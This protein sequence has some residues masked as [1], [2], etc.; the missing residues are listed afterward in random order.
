MGNLDQLKKLSCYEE[1]TDKHG[2]IEVRICLDNTTKVCSLSK[3]ETG[4][5]RIGLTNWR[6]RISTVEIELES[7]NNNIILGG[8]AQN[9]YKFDVKEHLPPSKKGVRN[10]H[11]RKVSAQ[12]DG[13]NSLSRGT[14]EISTRITTDQTLGGSRNGPMLYSVI[15]FR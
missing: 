2:M 15:K 7:L 13:G 9:P 10:E 1:T 12:R 4:T 6:S 8:K 5:Q 11:E 3:G 14:I